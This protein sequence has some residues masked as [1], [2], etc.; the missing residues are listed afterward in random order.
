MDIGLYPAW[1]C[2]LNAQLLPYLANLAGMIASVSGW[3]I[4]LLVVAESVIVFLFSWG[5][6]K[7]F[8]KKTFD[9]ERAKWYVSPALLLLTATLIIPIR[10]GFN[11]SPLNFSSVYFSKNLYANHSAYNFFWSFNYAVLH[12][13]V[14]TI[15][16]HYFG[17]AECI[18]NLNGIEQL[19]QEE[20]PVYIKKK[21]GK[22][23]N[24]ILVILE[25]F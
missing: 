4:L 14:K 12:N 17:D 19:N 11:T 1:G 7:I 10:G 22:P 18:N 21:T 9:G 25:S 3:Q 16:V 8:S 15:P 5:Y 6:Q 2:R 24:V 20:P 23:I 13:K